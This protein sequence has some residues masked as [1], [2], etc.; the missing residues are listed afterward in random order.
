ME[1]AVANIIERRVVGTDSATVDADRR[2]RRES[3]SATHG[4][5]DIQVQQ[6]WILFAEASAANVIPVAVAIRGRTCEWRKLSYVHTYAALRCDS[7][8]LR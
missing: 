3:T 2:R 1:R 6:I 8:A 5:N 7:A 4:D